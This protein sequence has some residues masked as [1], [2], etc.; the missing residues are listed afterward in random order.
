MFTEADRMALARSPA[1]REGLLDETTALAM[2]RAFARTTDRLAGW[3]TQLMA[4]AVGPSDPALEAGPCADDVPTHARRLDQRPA[5]RAGRCQVRRR[6]AASP[7]QDHRPARAPAGLRLATPPTASVRARWPM[8]TLTRRPR[9]GA[10]VGFADLVYFTRLVRR[11]SE[12]DLAGSCSVRGP[13]VRHRHR[14][15]RP[16]HQDRRRRGAVR[17]PIAAAPAAAMALD[18]VDTMAEDDVLPDVRVGMARG[19]GALAAR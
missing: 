3:Q 11:L 8:P 7:R 5:D 1:V 17:R 15:R 12:R 2:T 10:S 19:P 6:R 4:E 18:L 9:C 16:H 14:A 13:G